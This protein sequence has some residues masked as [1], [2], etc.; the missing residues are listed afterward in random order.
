MGR[1]LGSSF[2]ETINNLLKALKSAESQGRGEI[3]LSLQKV[4]NGLGGAAA[5]CHRDIYKNARS[6]LTDRSMSVRC[7]VARCLFELQNEAVFMWT[8]ELENVATLCFKA[9]EGSNYGVRVAVSKL[10]GTV[11]ATALMPKQAAVMRQNVKRATLD[12]VLELMSTG[13]LR[14]GSGFLKSGG[15]MLKG[16]G[17]VSREVRVGVTQH[18]TEWLCFNKHESI[19]LMRQ[20]VKR[21]TLDEVLELMSTGFLRGG[22]GFL[23]SGGEMLKGGGSV[24]REVRVG[25][26]QAYVVFVTTLGGQWLERNFATFLSHVL[27]LVSHPRATQT[28][29]EAVYSRRCVSF[30]LRATLGS[31]LGEKAQ[32]AAAKEI[33]QAIS[34]QMRAVEA[35]VNDAN[36]EN[37]AGAAD[38][39]ASQHVMVCALKELGSLVRSL[40]ATASPL[41]QEPSIGFLETVT[42]VLL[43][44]SMAA[45]LAAAWCLRCV[46]VALPYQLTPLLDRCAE[47][48]N[49]LKTSPEAVSGYSFA[50]AALLGGVHQCPLGIPHAKGKV[51]A[52]KYQHKLWRQLSAA[53]QIPSLENIEPTV[54]LAEEG[55]N[56]AKIQ[57]QAACDTIN[58]RAVANVVAARRCLQMK[59]STLTADT[60]AKLVELPFHSLALV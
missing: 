16:G 11:M 52:T 56:V 46:A 7:A 25:V 12:E 31:L 21:A 43:H 32:I 22:S 35:V 33:C 4:L 42:S 59:T 30:L 55:K 28:H 2:P 36:N 44:P 49:N 1:M 8:T 26:T 48:I 3:L 37:K 6:L 58:A 5:S 34:K 47:C 38:V 19:N 13:F 20:N 53:L 14:G 57:L 15:E 41:I 51:Y 27:D 23:K 60:K 9:L 18:N 24:S 39:S 50:M 10:L 54:Q 17:S 40:S 45:R 29:V